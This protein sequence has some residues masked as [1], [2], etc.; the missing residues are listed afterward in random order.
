MEDSAA[1]LEQAFLDI[2]AA[3]TGLTPDQNGQGSTVLF[4]AA[5]V[6]HLGL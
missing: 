3:G 2:Y 6:R 1:R 5:L 4:I